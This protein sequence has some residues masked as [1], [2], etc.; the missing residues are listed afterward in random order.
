[1]APRA[2]AASIARCTAV[3]SPAITYLPRRVEVDC[4]DDLALRGFATRRLDLASSRPMIAAIAPLSRGTEAC[5]TWPAE[6]HQIHGHAEIKRIRTDERGV[7]AQGCG[8][9]MAAGRG[10]PCARH[11]R[12]VATQAASIAG[13]CA[14]VHPGRS[15]GPFRHSSQRS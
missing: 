7:F 1:L 4:F 3:L 2:F 15:Q 14:P 10:P 5:I 8:P 9:A 13:W 11:T 6:T 12:Q